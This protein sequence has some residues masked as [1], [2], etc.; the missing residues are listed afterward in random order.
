MSIENLGNYP[1][2]PYDLSI[3]ASAA[4]AIAKEMV[5]VT[6]KI[7]VESTKVQYWHYT[8]QFEPFEPEAITLSCECPGGGDTGMGRLGRTPR[9]RDRDSD[10]SWNAQ[11]FPPGHLTKQQKWTSSSS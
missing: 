3:S 11:N 6:K 5:R 10:H 4:E 2:V 7:M 9:D 8:S 1:V